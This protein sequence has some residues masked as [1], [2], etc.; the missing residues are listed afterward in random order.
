MSVINNSLLLTAP[1]GGG[2]YQI[3][4][5]LRFNGPDTANFTRTPGVAGSLTTW[6]WAGWVKRGVTSG[7]TCLFSS[8][9][10]VSNDFTFNF[11]G[12]SF[13]TVDNLISV[14]V[15]D[16]SKTSIARFRDTSAWY[17]VVLNWDTTNATAD[18]RIRLYVNGNRLDVNATTNPTLSATSRINT[19]SQH[20]LGGYTPGGIAYDGYMADVYFIDGQALDPSS[21]TAT[22]ATTGQLIPKTY[23]GTY[24]T[25]GWHLDFS[26]NS[27]ATATTLGKDSSG[28]SRN[29]TP[30]NFSVTAGVGNDSLVDTPTS[31]GTDTGVGG[32]VRGNYCTWNP[33]IRGDTATNGN[34]DVTN[35]TARG[36]QKLLEYNAYWEITSTGGTTTAGVVSD[37]GTTNTTTVAN[38]KT[39]GFK[40]SAAGSLEYINITDGGSFTSII[41]GLTGIWFPYASADSAATG[42]LNAGQRPFAATAPSSFKALCDTNLPTPTI[43]KPNTVMDVALWTGNGA[44]RSITGLS[45]NPDLVW[46][47]SR[48]AA[49]DHKLT[50]S[51]RGVTKSLV[52]NSAAAETTDT[53]GLTAFNSDGF[54]LGTDTNYNN[55]AATYVAWAWDA[56]TST[57]TNTAGSITSQV[58]ANPSA[59]FSV[60]TFTTQSSGTATIGHGLNTA[61]AFIITK[62]RTFGAGYYCYHSSIGPTRWIFLETT[63]ANSNPSITIWNDT[64]PTSTVW[65]LGSGLAGSYSIVAY[66]FAPVSGNSSF[67]SYTGNGNIDGPFVYLGFRPAVVIVKMTSSTGNWTILDS[68]RIGYNVDNNPLFPNL[69]TAEGTTDLIDITSTGFKVRTTDATFNTNAGTY[70]Y[71]AWA[72]SPFQYARAR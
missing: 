10:G 41:T 39:Y 56:G 27:A 24:G 64:A 52:S 70:L 8:S 43:I 14:G 37:S 42:S 22:N 50:D 45:F 23:A 55:N 35:D 26:D 33:L 13:L 66:C 62:I 36:T 61:P 18:N 20:C 46:L 2:E 4:R 28:N 65:S 30:N 51:V 1:A 63:A 59:G 7:A 32:S 5:S 12:G 11:N 68:K 6:T 69:T 54:S 49:T 16:G 72:E 25:Q 3:A 47:K 57:V 31:Y 44:A 29:W 48:S 67:G 60:A 58:R 40:L 71:A 38:G 53:N 15:L 9:D 21:F 17:H 34:L 19:A